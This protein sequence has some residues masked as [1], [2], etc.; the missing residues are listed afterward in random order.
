MRKLLRFI[1]DYRKECLLGP[2][3]KMLEAA[4]ELLV[5]LVVAVIIDQGI[6]GADKGLVL[7]WGAVLVGLGVVGLCS[8][9]TAQYF[10]A[11]AA[12]YFAGKVRRELFGHIQSLSF[13]QYDSLGGD[14][15]VT[16]MTSDV[17]QVQTGVNLTLRLLLRSPFIVFGAMI[18]A[19][20]IDARAASV[21]AVAIAALSVVVFGIML[22]SIPR[23]KTVQKNLDGI[24]AITRENLAG[25]RVLRAFNK[26]SSER[27]QFAAQN[28]KVTTFGLFVGRV[29]AMMNPVTYVLINAALVMLIHT[30][31]LRVDAG[32]LTQGQVVALVNY[33]SQILIE[34]IKM[35]N[36]IITITKAWAC[37]NRVQALLEIPAESRRGETAAA[38]AAPMVEFRGVSLTYPGAGDESLTDISFSVPK[39]Q[40]FGIIGGTGS[41][42]SSVVNLIPGFY[43]AT[44][45]QVLVAGVDAIR[46]DADALRQKVGLVPQK[47]LLFRGT[48]RENLRWGKADACEAEMHTALEIAQAADFV[49]DK[50]GGL[51]AAVEQGGRNFSGG[52]RQRLAIARAVLRR[53]DILILDDSASALDYATEARLRAAIRGM[54]GTTVFLVSQRTSSIRH[55]DQILVLDDGQAV[56]LGTHDALLE[57]CPV[58]REIYD[59]QYQKEA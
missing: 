19:F 35:A 11:K 44:A 5:P 13:A 30:G 22:W 15:L 32:A 4:F 53:P 26:Q 39:G 8:A 59:S 58:Y 34:L 27:E 52:Q 6:G 16:R 42:K 43:K 31:A 21:F 56:G 49:A 17:N 50:D 38:S 29:S 54:E 33:T 7:R 9:I 28:Q 47:S 18:M 10:A 12:V 37:G 57:T 46:W 40:V 2:V 20:T 55:A 25:V 14:T 24:T 48:I 23:Y 3:F 1:R 41:G 51:D 45:G 36:L